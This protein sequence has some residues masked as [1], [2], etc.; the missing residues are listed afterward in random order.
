MHKSGI[1]FLFK[2][3]GK[4]KYDVPESFTRY[5][6]F[7]KLYL[8]RIMY[9]GSPEIERQLLRQQDFLV[10]SELHPQEIENLKANMNS[11][12]LIPGKKDFCA[13]QVNNKNGFDVLNAVTPP[14]TKRGAVLI[15]PS[16]EETSDYENVTKSI[17]Q[18]NKKWSNGI[19]MLWYPLLAHR[20]NEIENMINSITDA[21][22]KVNQNT[23]IVNLQLCV[24]SPD[25]HKEVSLEEFEQDK[26][27]PPRLYG[28][29]MLVI[30]SPWHLDEDGEKVIKFLTSFFEQKNL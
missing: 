5:L 22:K 15:D 8:N 29:G 26:K 4:N 13:I 9:P 2:E 25:S 14:K 23:E 1:Q 11:R 30:N 20:K 3:L 16:Y 6:D 28:S 24:N 21:A 17:I 7:I 18:V 19:I 27:N 12:S 10:L